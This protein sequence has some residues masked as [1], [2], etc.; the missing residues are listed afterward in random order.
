MT[1][2]L[3]SL[4]ARS[5][6]TEAAIRPRV[7]S[8]FE[9]VDGGDA[10]VREAPSTEPIETTVAREVEVQSDGARKR[11]HPAPALREDGTAKVNVN[12]NGA[13]YS[14]N[15][16]PVSV[17]PPRVSLESREEAALADE[18]IEEENSTVAANVRPR[19]AQPL[20]AQ[21]DDANEPELRRDS[22]D[23]VPGR[24]HAKAQVTA[25]TRDES[26]EHEHRGLVLPPGIA[27]EL[28]AQMKNAALAMNAGI[29][30]SA[31]DKMKTDSSTLAA[32]SEPT[33][34]VTIGRIEVRATSES[35]PAGRTR[36]ASP[37][38]SLDEYLHR[39]TQRGS[40]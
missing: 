31:R 1:D 5:F 13:K 7:A 15:A 28:T 37:V 36:A 18:K 11:S 8:L 34:H 12:V 27:S 9:P 20:Q 2:F 4:T 21:E 10:T 40:Q 22:E 32:E 30:A 35:K 39:R 25:N 6:G 26:L 33:I 16:N 14:A 29:N 19:R 17:L 38:M 3:A 24:A 23:S